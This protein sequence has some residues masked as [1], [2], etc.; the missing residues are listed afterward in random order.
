M[1][2]AIRDMEIAGPPGSKNAIMKK[3][4]TVKSDYAN[5]PGFVCANIAWSMFDNPM[6]YKYNCVRLTLIFAAR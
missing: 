1:A 6:V 2:K 4:G 5:V 3:P